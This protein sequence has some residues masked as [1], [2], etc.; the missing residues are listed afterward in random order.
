MV[1]VTVLNT[2]R[3]FRIRND[4]IAHY[5]RRV[6]RHARQRTARIGVICIG[7][8]R[9]RMLNRQFSRHDYVTDVISFALEKGVNLEGEI[10]VNLDRAR[11]QARFYRVSFEKELAR[12]VVHGALHLV[13]YDDKSPHYRDRM[14]AAEDEHII[15]WFPGKKP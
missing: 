13:G 15:H 7:S 6:L 10:Y 1:R 11:Q 4:R 12:L 14:R 5:V 3:R 2:Y 9:A 8:R